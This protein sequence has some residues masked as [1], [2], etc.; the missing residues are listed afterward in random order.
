MG[1]KRLKPGVASG[2]D[3]VIGVTLFLLLPITDAGEFMLILVLHINSLLENAKF[4]I[5]FCLLEDTSE[6]VRNSHAHLNAV[7]V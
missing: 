1:S 4:I 2:A 3:K 6:F 7:F 5:N